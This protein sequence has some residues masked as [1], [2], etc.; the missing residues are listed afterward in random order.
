MLRLNSGLR[1][2][3]PI[4][5][6]IKLISFYSKR[7]GNYFLKH[8]QAGLDRFSF[9]LINYDHHSTNYIK[10]LGSVLYIYKNRRNQ[11]GGQ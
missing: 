8:G 5:N 3:S 4:I 7:G 2:Q 11:E 10:F 1:K 9:L 6:L